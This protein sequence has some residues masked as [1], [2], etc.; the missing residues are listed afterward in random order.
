MSFTDDNFLEVL[1]LMLVV[2]TLVVLVTR[3]LR[4]PTIVSFMG[5]G[6]A[7]GPLASLFDAPLAVEGTVETIAEFGT[8]LLL[9]LVGLELSFARIKQV[10]KV[11]FAAGLGQVVFT[12]AGGYLLCWALGF[13]PLEGIVLAT[14]LTFSSTVVVVKLL[15]QKG[16]LHALY[17]RIAVGIF[18]VQDLVVVLV[19]ALLAGLGSP[20]AL[21]PSVLLGSIGRAFGGTLGLLA[22]CL[23]SARF[24][25]PPLFR[26]AARSPRTIFIFSLGWALLFVEVAHQLELSAEIGAFLAGISI[27]QLDSADELRRRVHPLMSFF[28]AVFFVSLG[29]RMEL[30]AA[31]AY[32]PEAL[33]LSAFVLLGNPFIF[34]WIIAR[35]R[36]SERT[37]FY[38]S[39]TVAQISE[40]SFVF[41]AMGV[42]TGLVGEHVLALVSVVGLLTIMASAYM[43]LYS[44][45]LYRIVR[46]LG[47]LRMFRAKQEE[48]LEPAAP[49]M[50]DHVIIVGMN[51]LGRRIATRLC[52][53][54]ENVLAVDVDRRKL[55]DL[56]CRTMVG[57][58]EYPAALE[59][60]ALDRAK[61][62]VSAL[63]IET[64]NKMLIFQAKVHGV[65]VVAYA[66]D[67]SAHAELAKLAPE[68][69][70]ESKSEAGSRLAD[71]V[72]RMLG[73]AA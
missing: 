45:P 54:G 20:E 65:P 42:T 21:E 73:E 63:R 8:V 18:L 4:V 3:R 27:A 19:L 38:T 59:A 10:G 61:L 12:A 35:F 24:L 55:E 64:T 33:V 62:L 46:R 49:R 68:L 67:R 44:E 43:I 56:P 11:A 52:R 23:L 9:F 7:V 37:C 2:A 66:V 25:L 5:A 14:A 32:L 15:D 47:I 48:D 30:V 53:S 40:F 39:V 70:I 71:E 29:A 26:W 50:N 60:A 69:L 31:H 6:L 51:D 16:E 57:S 41:A 34:M 58:F 13:E 17:G 28:V 72:S 1:G 22:A 36:Y